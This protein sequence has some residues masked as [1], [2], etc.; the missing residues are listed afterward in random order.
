MSIIAGVD[1]GN[2][3]TEAAIARVE[4]GDSPEFLSSGSTTTTGI[5]GTAENISGIVDVLEEATEVAGIG[6]DDL[7]LVL[8]NEATPVIGD[9]AMETVTETVV[10][11]SSMVGH[12]PGSPGGVGIGVGQ[13]TH[14]S[15]LEESDSD[16]AL[17]DEPIIVIVPKDYDFEAAADTITRALEAGVEIKA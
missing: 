10:T 17:P 6:M 5:K 4:D 13:T 8:L 3:T 9:V 7:D 11:E 1:I 2:S 16:G 14:I 15:D 12:N